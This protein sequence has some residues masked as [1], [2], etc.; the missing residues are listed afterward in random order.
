MII[1]ENKPINEILGFLKN[2][3]KVVLIGCNQSAAICKSGGEEEVL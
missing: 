3:E 1:S 2:V